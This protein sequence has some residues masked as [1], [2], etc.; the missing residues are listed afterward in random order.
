MRK[1][2]SLPILFLLVSCAPSIQMR[3]ECFFRIAGMNLTR[4]SD[5]LDEDMISDLN[6]FIFNHKGIMEESRYIRSGAMER[7]GS[8]IVFSASLILDE[9]YSVYVCANL[10]YALKA[11]SESELKSLRYHLAYPDE[12]SKGI[13]MTGSL[14][15]VIPSTGDKMIGLERMM[16]KLSIVFDRSSLEE[17]T[18]IW[19]KRVSIGNCPKSAILFGE[20]LAESSE[21][22]FLSGFSKDGTN[23]DPLNRVVS[24]GKSREVRLFMLENLHEQ[25]EKLSSYIELEL[26]YKSRLMQNKPGEYLKYRFRLGEIRR[27]SSYKF[28]VKPEGSGLNGDSWRVDKEALEVRESAKRFDLMPAAYNVCTVSDTFHLRCDVFPAETPLE[29]ELLSY[30]D[31]ERVAALY[32]YEIDKD[33]H[34]LRLM[35][36]KDGTAL[37]YFKAGPPVSKDTLAMVVFNPNTSP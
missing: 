35:P 9:K 11:N 4:S 3:Q 34:G 26:E 36:H 10:G 28:V 1:I 25:E 14:I 21:D 20:S 8:D 23:A 29:I 22:I 24:G 13:P 19:V 5:P 12:Y 6:I 30:E 31:D 18:E 37:I 33:G 32:D 7:E 16:S 2:I 27:N 17:G 15:N